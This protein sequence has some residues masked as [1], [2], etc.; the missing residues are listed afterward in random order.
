MVTRWG[1]L[2][3]GATCWVASAGGEAPPSPGVARVEL[4][5][6]DDAA[7]GYGTFQSHNQKVVSNPHGIF[8]THIR[9]RNE[10]YTAQQWRLLRS[11]DGGKRFLVVYEATNATNPPVLETDEAGT[12]YLARPDFADG[13]AYLYRFAAKD[14]YAK[15]QITK[16]PG[17]SAGKYCMMLDRVRNQLYFFAHNNTFHVVSLDGKVRS[18]RHLL[19]HGRHAVLQYPLLSLTRDDVLHAAWTTQKHGQY[20]YWD[21]HHLVSRDGGQS[22]S[23]MAGKPTTLPVVADDGG[24]AQR[25]TLDDE[26]EV[27]TWLSSLMA[28]D[29][30]VHFLYMA[31]T[32]PTAREHYVR[33]DAETGRQDVRI[34][35]EFRGK[36]MSLMGLS[37]AF[38][39]R[40]S[41][42]GG[43]LY[44]VSNASGRIA[45][46]A[47]DDNG[48]TWYDYAVSDKTY[49][50]YS[51]GG[52]RELTADGY[53]IGSFTNQSASPAEVSGKC[54]VYFFRIQAG[55]SRAE[56][57]TVQT[58][59]G[60]VTVKFADVRGQPAKVRFQGKGNRW[61]DWVPFRGHI[62]VDERPRAFQLTSRLGVVS[63]VY[64]IKDGGR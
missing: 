12:V 18:S 24:P 16:I 60:G 56:A 51:I 47:S 9:T 55:L 57:T 34:W 42:D 58:P 62:K 40:A 50:P 45:C 49:R 59:G 36:T 41:L 8:M 30:K 15:P 14:A 6:V 21:I 23:T 61:R 43:S 4:T 39:A 52:C 46:L 5:C 63:A 19:R 35:P 13:H 29:G 25:I 26:F 3:F 10:A 33:Y 37:G 44:C 20:L 38:A 54:S 28:K 64:E 22:W 31:Q 17:A 2:L 11:V 1:P 53:L 7:T 27:H 32:K 48:R